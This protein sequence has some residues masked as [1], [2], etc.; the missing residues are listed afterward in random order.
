MESPNP[1]KQAEEQ[2]F[3]LR[4]K[5]ETGRITR[6]QFEAA[7]H[8]L[9]VEDAQG[10]HWVPGVDSGKWFVHDG[11]SWVEANPYG[12]VQPATTPPRPMG[13]PE[14]SASSVRPIAP[15]PPPSPQPKQSR[16]CAGWLVPGCLVLVALVVVLGA[17][18][19][20]AFQNRLITLNTVLSLIGMGPADI[21][22]NNFRDDG[23]DVTVRE[24]NPAQGSSP[25]QG[26]LRLNAFDVKAYRAQNPG[27]YR[28][29]FRATRG[30][31]DLGACALTV[32][33]GEQYQF[34]VLPE[35]I[36]V[37]RANNPSTVGTDFVI[38]TSALC[39]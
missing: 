27:R 38:Q 4:G 7:L 31:V 29:E 33:S 25:S 28:V 24:L 35:R 9:M 5:L 8:D 18:G 15:P 19:F 37:N 3:I 22:I 21:E 6:E 10:R 20:Y 17:G 1:F 13:M 2:Y 23:I 14:R 26:S 39:R 34:V 16:G 30:A 32:K 12:T 11:R 36:V